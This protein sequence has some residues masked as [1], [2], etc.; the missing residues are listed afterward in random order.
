VEDWSIVKLGPRVIKTGIA[1][2][3]ALYIC[4]VLNL[5]SAVFAGIAAI[6]T[7]QP[8]IY[9]TWKQVGNQVQTNIIGAIIAFLGLYFLGNDPFSIGL[10]IIILISISLKLKM[11]ETISLTV[12]TV[13]AIMSAPGNEDWLFALNRF[14][15]T[16]IG[17]ATALLVNI[18][19]YPPN[20][21]KNYV[22]KV[23]EIFQSMSILIRTAISDEMTEKCFKEQME[24][25]ENDI[26]LLE[27]QFRLF[28]EEREKMAK[29]NNMDV[30]EIV[31]FKQMFKS[32][33]QG[34]IVLEDIDSFYFSCKPTPEEN[35]LFDQQL[36]YLIKYHELFLLKYD[37][38]IKMD[39]P[40]LEDEFMKQTEVFLEK[41]MQTYNEGQK[42][43]MAVIGASIYNYAFQ[44]D[45]LN[46]L[47][48]Q[49]MKKS[50]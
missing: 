33:Q 24:K 14:I 25:L 19:V 12:V 18:F 30:R 40:S 15:V 4:S 9:R 26:L 3:F 11:G 43:Q 47:V 8:S 7:I 21:K 50:Q 31:V 42:I 38:K 41:V 44:L 13:L 6:F 28:D 22:T 36:E 45:R 49:Y 39:L 32:L 20:Y 1:V 27:E 16:F 35:Q 34:F 2:T 17:M 23:N 10:V 48:E 46:T 37:G 5:E 29:L